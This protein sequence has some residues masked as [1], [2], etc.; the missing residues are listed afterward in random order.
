MYTLLYTKMFKVH[1]CFLNT[2]VHNK[3]CMWMVCETL[4]VLLYT[5]SKI[6]YCCVFMVLDNFNTTTHPGLTKL[7]VYECCK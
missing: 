2:L 3:V 6:R 4:F 7:Y 5:C 1:S